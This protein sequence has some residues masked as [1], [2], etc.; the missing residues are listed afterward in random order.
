MNNFQ[1]CF[2]FKNLSIIFDALSELISGKQPK[3][4]DINGHLENT[5]SVARLKLSVQLTVRINL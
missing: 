5:G 3:F 4:K 2:T 1:K